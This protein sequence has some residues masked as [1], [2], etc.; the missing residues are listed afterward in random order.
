MASSLRCTAGGRIARFRGD[1][2]F[3]IGIEIPEVG[4]SPPKKVP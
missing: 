1:V 4:Y 2:V 3:L